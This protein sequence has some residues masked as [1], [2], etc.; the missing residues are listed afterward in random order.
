MLLCARQF[1]KTTSDYHCDRNHNFLIKWEIELTYFKIFRSEN[2]EQREM[3]SF[4]MN[5]REIF[6]QKFSCEKP[7]D[8]AGVHLPKFWRYFISS[9]TLPLPLY[10]PLPIHGLCNSTKQRG[11]K[12]QWALVSLRFAEI[13]LISDTK[14]WSQSWAIYWF[15]LESSSSICS[16]FIDSNWLGYQE[17]S[18]YWIKFQQFD[19]DFIKNCTFIKNFTVC[20]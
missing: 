20:H 11:V 1:D 19:W 10:I 17:A 8:S 14:S 5:W 7:R 9:D 2:S 3:I 4:N 12:F 6:R 16:G 13:R 18:F 15:Q